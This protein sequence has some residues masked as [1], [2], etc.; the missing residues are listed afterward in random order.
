MWKPRLEG[1]KGI[2]QGHMEVELR[3]KVLADS[4]GQGQLHIQGGQV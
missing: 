1:Y 4:P 3:P 2:C